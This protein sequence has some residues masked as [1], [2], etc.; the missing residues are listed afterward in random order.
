VIRVERRAL[1]GELRAD[2]AGRRLQGYA[3]VF[4]QDTR[5]GSFLERIRPGAFRAS[6]GAGGDVLALADHDPARLLARTRSGTLRLAEDGK[7]LAF[8]LDVPDTALGHDMLT[9]AA[10]GDLGG[11]SIGFRVTADDWPAADRRELRQV[12]LV[13]VSIVQAFPAYEGTEVH[14]RGKG[15]YSKHPLSPA[16][17]RRM[18]EAL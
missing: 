18:V 6:L 11:A 3:A 10:R 1:A 8:D 14:A 13:E 15:M 16:A 2:T 9:L 4:D 12:E 17:R 5:I 7:G